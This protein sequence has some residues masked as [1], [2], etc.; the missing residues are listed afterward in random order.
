MRWGRVARQ[1]LLSAAQ[2]A[3]ERLGGRVIYGSSLQHLPFGRAALRLEVTRA[4]SRARKA[5]RCSGAAGLVPEREK[6]D[7]SC[8]RAQGGLLF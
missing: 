4:F 1:P 8:C 2:R 5:R 7:R 6:Q 3:R